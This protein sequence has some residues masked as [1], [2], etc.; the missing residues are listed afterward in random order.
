MMR[1]PPRPRLRGV[2]LLAALVPALLQAARPAAA[3]EPIRA[4]VELYTSQGCAVCA[5]ADQVLG[6]LA[7]R[8]GILALT[9]PVTYWD[10]LGWKDTLAQG[11]FTERQRAYAGARGE[12][13]VYTP[14]AVING[15]AAAMGS[16]RT[17]LERM[18]REARA[19]NALRVPVESEETGDRIVVTVGGD[20]D[21]AAGADVWLIPVLRQ[22]PVTIERGE[23][24]GRV[25]IYANVAR[26]LHRL[27][28]WTGQPARFEAPSA[29][30][31]VGEADSY[32]VVVQGSIGSRQGR[33]WGAAKGP[34][35]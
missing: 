25:V 33:I 2:A 32:V 35:L 30:A 21:P 19:V 17:Q 10:Y 7:R 20:P 26:G 34:G 16:D 8:P 15:A 24:K 27:G 31:H 23:N 29:A 6:D 5:P 13:Q 14:Q 28:A 3:A 9:F 11:I 18:I 1:V 22:R 4:V 12:R